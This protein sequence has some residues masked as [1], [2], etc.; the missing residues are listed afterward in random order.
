MALIRTIVKIA[1][2]RLASDPEIQRKMKNT[3]KQ[4]VIPEA[5]QRWSDIKPEIEKVALK[6]KTLLKGLKNT[7]KN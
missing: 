3:I 2:Q 7:M 1:L 5:K 6:G 4:D